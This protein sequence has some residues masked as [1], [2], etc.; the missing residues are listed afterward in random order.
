ME[1]FYFMVVDLHKKC[2]KTGKEIG[3]YVFDNYHRNVVARSRVAQIK[4]VIDDKLIELAQLNPRCTPLKSRIIWIKRTPDE[5][6]LVIVVYTNDPYSP[7][8][9]LSLAGYQI[10]NTVGCVLEPMSSIQV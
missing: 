2:N 5:Q 1:E 3:H 9:V 4:K 7:S 6:I 8:L 10:A